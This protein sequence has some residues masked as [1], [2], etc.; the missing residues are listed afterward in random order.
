MRMTR[1]V[2]LIA[3]IWFLLLSI[4]IVPPAIAASPPWLR[5]HLNGRLNLTGV[6]YGISFADYKGKSPD[7]DTMRLAKDRALAKQSFEGAAQVFAKAI[8]GAGNY[9]LLHQQSLRLPF[10][11]SCPQKLW[12]NRWVICS[13]RTADRMFSSF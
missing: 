11:R 1:P 5:D 13:A 8:E 4:G 6:Y 9:S 3:G 10:L 2:F 12:I 7:Y